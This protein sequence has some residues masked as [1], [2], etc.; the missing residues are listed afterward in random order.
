MVMDYD[1]S[2]EQKRKITQL[3][4]ALGIVEPLEEAQMTIGTAG[5]LIRQLLWEL[6]QD[7]ERKRARQ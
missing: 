5:V 2:P 4:M 7:K 1:A 3:C 6:K